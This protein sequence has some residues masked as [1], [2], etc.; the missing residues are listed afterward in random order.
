MNERLSLQD[1]IDLLAKKQEITKKEAEVFLRELIA[2]ISETIESNESVKIKDF[3]TFKL[4]KVNA[5]KSVDVNTGEAIEIAAHYKLSFTPDK[6]LKEAINRPFAHFESVV[7]EEGVSFDNI[8]KDETVNIEEADEEEDVSVDEETNEVSP[9]PTA[10]SHQVD[11]EDFTPELG[12]EDTT[13]IETEN[14]APHTE[15]EQV[16]EINNRK[17]EAGHPENEAIAPSETENISEPI[18]DEVS[19]ER[20]LEYKQRIEEAKLAAKEKDLEYERLVKETRQ[21]AK[22][23]KKFVSLGFFIFLIIAA[24]L[25]GGLYFQEIARF[26]TEGPIGNGNTAMVADNQNI[27]EQKTDTLAVSSDSIAKAKEQDSIAIATE[28]TLPSENSIKPQTQKTEQPTATKGNTPLAIITIEP[29]NTLRNIS[30]KY[31]GHKSFCVYIYEEN[32]DKIKNINSIPLGTKLTI[33]SPSKYGINLQDQASLD[34]A[35]AKEK[36]LFKTMGL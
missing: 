26:L 12:S 34:K 33:P 23:R 19:E 27:D 5:R 35:K 18:T 30:L 6:L 36:E 3:G 2:V 28:K 17:E 21:A 10:D 14:T 15:E 8:E 9:T 25:I 24:F 29:G 31:Y 32:K 20:I 11:N 7:L 13:I 4:V 16:E 22:R 1:L